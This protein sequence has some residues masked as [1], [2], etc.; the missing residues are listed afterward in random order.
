MKMSKTRM[1][2]LVKNFHTEKVSAGFRE[3][4]AL[5]KLR[6]ERGRNWL[7][8]CASVDVSQKHQLNP[9]DSVRVAG[10][11]LGLGIGV[12]EPA[13]TEGQWH[14]TPLW[15][16]IA[17]GR[18]L[19]LAKFLLKSG[20]SPAHCLWAASFEEDLGMLKVLIDAGAPLEAVA[21]GETALLGA[22]KHNKFKAA[23]FLLDAG[24]DPDFQDRRGMT[25]LHYMLKKN[26][27]KEHYQMFV[28]HRA[29][30]DIANSD[31]K[32]ASGVLMRKRD[33][34]FHRISEQLTTA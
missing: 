26:S 3:N 22:V 21:E 34:E 18:N 31:A 25:A 8:L 15:Y 2:E 1:I 14:A 17:R 29:R 23:A 32:T 30:G 7:H 33:P 19:P 10:T 5:I 20:S 16:A 13:F 28:L 4:P 11:L 12:N 27:D 6:D 9:Q 24:S